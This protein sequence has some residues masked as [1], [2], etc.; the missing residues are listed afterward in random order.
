MSA[1]VIERAPGLVVMAFGFL[2]TVELVEAVPTAV[3]MA[4]A[5]PEKKVAVT[6]P[7][8]VVPI[9]AAASTGSVGVIV[10]AGQRHTLLEL[11]DRCECAARCTIPGV[12]PTL[13]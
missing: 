3:G 6:V 12:S 8:F 9:V 7:T 13:K 1:V 4:F 10:V 11:C 5:A 2:S